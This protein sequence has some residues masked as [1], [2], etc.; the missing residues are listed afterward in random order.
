MKYVG[1]DIGKWKCRAAVMDPLPRIQPVI[2][3]IPRLPMTMR[4][5][6]SFSAISTMVAD[7]R[8]SLSIVLTFRSGCSDLTLASTSVGVAKPMGLLHADLLYRFEVPQP[9]NSYALVHLVHHV[10]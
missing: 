7:D 10:T 9:Q 4:S 6:P 2:P 1:L 3:L 8:P 5:Y